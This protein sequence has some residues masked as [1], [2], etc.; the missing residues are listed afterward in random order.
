ML[1]ASE[2]ADVK[3]WGLTFCILSNNKFR[4][5]SDSKLINDRFK[6]EIKSNI[7]FNIEKIDER[8]LYNVDYVKTGQD[9]V[10]KTT[11]GLRTFDKVK[12]AVIIQDNYNLTVSTEEGTILQDGACTLPYEP[13]SMILDMKFEMLKLKN[14]HIQFIT[15][16]KTEL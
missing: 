14:K 13:F 1:N 4:N 3:S 10:K 7:N 16:T 15:N 2:F 11:K 8:L 9:W 12:Y 6:F 5:T